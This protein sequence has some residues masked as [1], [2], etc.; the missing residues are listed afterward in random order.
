[1]SRQT[2]KAF[3]AMHEFLAKNATEDMSMDEVNEMLGKF[4]EQYNSNIPEDVTE[5]TAKTADDFVELALAAQEEDDIPEA[6]RFARKALKIDPDNLDAELIVAVYGGA[7]Y[8]DTVKRLERAVA[9]GTK[10][11]EKEGYM[12]DSVGN[13]WGVLETRPYM[14]LR[15]EYAKALLEFGMYRRAIA[16]FEELIRLC[17]NDN[18]GNRYTLM[19]LY[20]FM[21][22]KEEA[23]ALHEKYENSD[24]AQMLMPLAMM[25]YK[26][27]DRDNAEKY[28]KRIAKSNKDL[29]KFVKAFNN[30]ELHKYVSEMDH[31]GYRPY[32]IEELIT[33]MAE[34]STLFRLM[35]TFFDWAEDVLKKR[36]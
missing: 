36:K 13:F 11:M 21:E 5:K 25:Y 16:E 30:D 3:K 32:S 27:G 4:M 2:E 7:K 17:D 8:Y 6:L 24:E 22:M 15:T 20:A 29:L 26:T 10:I 14:R 18:M 23:L 35:W 31:M 33:E 1:M 19:H 28:L 9:K 12:T 34:N